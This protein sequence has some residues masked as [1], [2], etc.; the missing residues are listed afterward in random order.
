M[1]SG[2]SYS[3]NTTN[4]GL[5]FVAK[6]PCNSVAILLSECQSH[7]IEN[8]CAVPVQILNKLAV[9]APPEVTRQGQD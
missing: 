3:H 7:R 6:V 2:R 8:S 5:Y 4:F 9:S 1:I